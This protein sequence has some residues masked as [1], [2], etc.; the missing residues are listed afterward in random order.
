MIIPKFLLREA[1]KSQL[2]VFAVLVVIFVSRELVSVLSKAVEGKFAGDMLVQVVLL[3]LPKLFILVFPISFFLGILFAFGRMYADSEMVVLRACGIS[4]WYVTRVVLL[5]AV[6]SM[7]ICAAF[8]FVITP[9]SEQQKD[10][11]MDDMGASTNISLLSEGRFRA[12]PN[13]SAVVFVEKIADKGKKMGNIFI[14]QM[15]DSWG[16][17]QR[18]DIVLAKSGTVAEKDNGDALV[19]LF[20]GHRYEGAPTQMDYRVMGFEEYQV[21]VSVGGDENPHLHLDAMSMSQLLHQDDTEAVAEFHWRLAVPL[22]I[23]ILALIAVPLASVN[24]RQGK[25][26]KLFPAIM[27]YL[28][29]FVLLMTG[30]KALQDGNVPDFVGLWWVHLSGL[31][32][33]TLMVLNG[34]P[35]GVRVR[36]M[37]RRGKAS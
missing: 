31:L 26:A 2:A 21:P 9:W 14:A 23:P 11:L 29:Y 1:V 36:A 17:N 25:F 24:P 34:R 18:A 5:L 4:E 3:N 32:I 6:L 10:Q 22:A 19:T 35:V 13:G 20:D 30:R 7:L 28:G 33:G 15:P 16:P 12:S 37:L 27:L 8:S